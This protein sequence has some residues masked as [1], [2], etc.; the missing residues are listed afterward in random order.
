[1]QID[2]YRHARKGIEIHV[3]AGN[4]V[5]QAFDGVPLW[6]FRANWEDSTPETI[7]AIEQQGWRGTRDVVLFEANIVNHPSS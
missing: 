4:P 3:P 7:K 5:P 2:T 6:L 1:M